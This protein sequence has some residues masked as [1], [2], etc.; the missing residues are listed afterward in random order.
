MYSGLPVVTS[1]AAAPHLV[2]STL[3]YVTNTARLSFTMASNLTFVANFRDSTRPV[4]I[5][6]Y[7]AAKQS[8]SNSPITVT[9]K[10]SDNVGVAGVNYQLNGG[11]WNPADLTDATD[12]QAPNLALN[13]GANV[14]QAFAT[15]AAGN[16]SLTN[17][18][19][20]NYVSNGPAAG[21]GP[22]PA[23]LAGTVAEVNINGGSGPFFVDFG[24]ATFAQV[25]TNAQDGG[26]GDYTYTLLSSNTALLN[27]SNLLPPQ[28]GSGALV[29]ITFT[30]D[31]DGTFTDTNDQTGTITFSNAP[32]LAPSPSSI[33][34]AQTVD[35]LGNTNILTLGGGLFTNTVGT[36]VS[37]GNYYF[38]PFSPLDMMLIENFTD[39]N[40]ASN[41]AY[42]QLDFSSVTNG[43]FFYD[44][45]DEYYD[46]LGSDSGA[47]TILSTASQPSGLAPDSAAGLIWYAKPN[48]NSQN[49]NGKIQPPFYYYFGT[50]TYSRTSSSNTDTNDFDVGIYSYVKTGEN[51][52]QFTSFEIAPQS[53]APG[54][55]GGNGGN[56]SSLL[57]LTFTSS[58]NITVTNNGIVVGAITVSQASNLAPA[59][60]AGDT[61]TVTFS[62]NTA[63]LTLNAD[64]TFNNNDSNGTINSGPYSYAPY[65]PIGAMVILNFTSGSD[66]GNT[67][68]LELTFS[69]SKSGSA[70]ATTFDNM[71]NEVDVHGGTFKIQ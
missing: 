44:G 28:N 27:L 6:T 25:V 45:F 68:Y 70:F 21:S 57:N 59:S 31:M 48:S 50:S 55:N 13:V 23:S 40:D 14:I 24:T 34:T 43:Q 62:G 71:G 67:G 32:D 33:I 8:V 60:V 7:P 5:I 16:V 3:L 22:A 35:I 53:G 39:A 52:A 12:W 11:G 56:N 42:V 26:T 4:C 41:I 61:F 10:A 63:T 9:G 65:S 2:T 1:L 29:T 30:N 66:V 54:G 69:T 64:G 36:T 18:I 49:G 17:T 15:D 38:T 20:F 58:K 37:F 19:N 46:F 51:T 47:F